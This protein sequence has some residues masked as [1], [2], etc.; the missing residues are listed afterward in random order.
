M[1]FRPETP[2][3][4]DLDVYEACTNSNSVTDDLQDIR[5]NIKDIWSEWF[6]LAVS[7]AANVGV[8]PSIPSPD[9][10]ASALRQFTSPDAI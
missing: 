8:V 6:D 7:T 9:Q 5:D 2:E 3:K 4:R 10:S 1:P